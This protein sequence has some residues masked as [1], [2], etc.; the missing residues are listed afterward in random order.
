MNAYN[1]ILK[2]F[3]TI[4][5]SMVSKKHNYLRRVETAAF[6]KILSVKMFSQQAFLI[7]PYPQQEKK[8]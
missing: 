2:S 8:C 6:R 1:C 5:K 3:E 7:F 4:V